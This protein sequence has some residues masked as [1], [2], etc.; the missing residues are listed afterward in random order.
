MGEFCYDSAGCPSLPSF[1]F[2]DPQVERLPPLRLPLLDRLELLVFAIAGRAARAAAA[3]S[4]A[5]RDAASSLDRCCK[6][7][8]RGNGNMNR[9]WGGE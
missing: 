2:P 4:A 3:A 9:V 6:A 7:R 8:Q 5:L 1:D